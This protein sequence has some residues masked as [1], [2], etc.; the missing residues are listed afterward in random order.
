VPGL[1]IGLTTKSTGILRDR[2]LL[3]RIARASDLWVN[4]SLI[5]LDAALLRQIEPRA[6]RPDLRLEAMRT[7]AGDG[8][9]VRLFLMPVLPMLTDGAASLRELLGGARE[10]GAREVIS[11]ALFLRSEMTWRFFLDFVER[12]FPWAW[13]RYRALYPGPGNAPRGY[14]EEIERRVARLAAEAGFPSRTRDERVRAE[15]PA[16]PRQLSLEW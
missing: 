5:S 6:P 7:L 4:I 1:R 11:Q 13:L 2:D 14:R 16:R 3:A 12:E 9:R 8:I 10:A 15:A